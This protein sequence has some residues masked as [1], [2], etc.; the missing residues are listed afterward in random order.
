VTNSPDPRALAALLRREI[1]GQVELFDSLWQR[2]E[3]PDDVLAP[4]R[5]RTAVNRFIG[6]AQFLSM[7]HEKGDPAATPLRTL[8]GWQKRIGAL[9]DLDVLRQRMQSFLKDAESAP[10]LLA[11]EAMLALLQAR[12][13][14]L[15]T[16]VRIDARGFPGADVRV[17]LRLL[18]S[19]FEERLLQLENQ[20]ESF[21]HRRAIRDVFLPW[22]TY[23]QVLHHAHD[24]IPLHAF[25]VKN[26]RLR[27]A[28]D[29]LVEWTGDD[30]PQRHHAKVVTEAHN[31]L[32]DLNDLYVL[33]K[34][35]R[36]ARADW[37][38]AGREE[39]QESAGA[40]ELLRA[41]KEGEIFLRWYALWPEL[42][43][44]L[45]GA[46]RQD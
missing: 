43:S 28:L 31:L 9:R 20:P 5:Q 42:S 2:Y 40:L 10:A 17:A 34:T 32:G 19:Q 30:S 7:P 18:L 33:K 37:S 26:K 13:Q 14:T 12:R 3:L 6:Y 16:D 23:R 41:R 44:P 1:A 45:V 46:D 8:K 27:F 39:L 15:L 11:V 24:D 38:L 4:H 36:L 25:R 29:L 21:D 22:D 35:I